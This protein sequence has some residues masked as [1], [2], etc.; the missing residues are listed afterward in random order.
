V[1]RSTGPAEEV[2]ARTV[3]LLDPI[4]EWPLNVFAAD[5]AEAQTPTL[6]AIV[7]ADLHNLVFQADFRI[8]PATTAG[9]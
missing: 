2:F 8:I 5:E 7:A 4:G 1:K 3:E 6:R 9:R